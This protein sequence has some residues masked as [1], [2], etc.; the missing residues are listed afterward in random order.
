MYWP[1][2]RGHHL[3]VSTLVCLVTGQVRAD[4]VGGGEKSSYLEK[5]GAI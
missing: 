5:T 4:P 2:G 1:R 3:F